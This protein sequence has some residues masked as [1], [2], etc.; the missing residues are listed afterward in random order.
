MS[1][2]LETICKFCK[3]DFITKTRLKRHQA[4]KLKCNKNIED[5]KIET[6]SI[7]KSKNI[8]KPINLE[9]LRDQITDSNLDIEEISLL[10]A[11]LEDYKNDIL[12]N[13]REYDITCGNCG[14][15][16]TQK[17][18]LYRHA[19]LNRCKSK[20]SSRTE[21]IALDDILNHSR[22]RI[23][24]NINGNNNTTNTTNTTN[25][26]NSRN[27]NITNFFINVNP[28]GLES[29]NHISIRDFK[30]IFTNIETIMDKL[31]YHIFNRHVP[32]ISFYKNN[33]N[34]QIVSYLNKNLE[35]KLIDE[36]VF[37][38]KLRDFLEDLC[39]QLFHNFRDQLSEDEL[40]QYMRN[41]VEYQNIVSSD[42]EHYITKKTKSSLSRLL[43]YAFRNKD[44][45]MAIDN[46]IKQLKTDIQTKMQLIKE[47]KYE[48]TKRCEISNEFYKKDIDDNIIDG[49][50]SN[51][52]KLLYV[53]RHKA[54]KANENADKECNKRILKKNIE[55]I[56]FS[57]GTH[58]E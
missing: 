13:T 52:H 47:H 24:T 45:K 36:K 15:Q 51:N 11:Y 6:N 41:L 14:I 20:E 26:D 33:L 25:I 43:E 56:N 7:D 32:N 17:K 50:D 4:N 28:L 5:N 57:S 10:I 55:S 29:I 38:N 23:N 12:E 58:D 21:G 31:S 46:L 19:R 8:T 35:I 34:K 30:S 27:I 2:I 1:K 9:S 49:K 39:I 53:L 54:K 16:F 18:S 3:K 44:I 37:L 42:Y 22:D 40:I 48:D